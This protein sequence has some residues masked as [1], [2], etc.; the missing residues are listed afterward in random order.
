MQHLFISM[1]EPAS[2]P[3]CRVLCRNAHSNEQLALASSH[4]IPIPTRLPPQNRHRGAAYIWYTG[5]TTKGA[6]AL[7]SFHPAPITY[8]SMRYAAR[9]RLTR[10]PNR[11]RGPPTL[12]VACTS[13]LQTISGA[14]NQLPYLLKVPTALLGET[15]TQRACVAL[16]AMCCQKSGADAPSGG[17]LATALN[18]MSR[19]SGVRSGTVR[20]RVVPRLEIHYLVHAMPFAPDACLPA[21]RKSTPA[22][23]CSPSRRTADKRRTDGG[24]AS[25]VPDAS[26]ECGAQVVG[27]ECK[28]SPAI[29]RSS[30]TRHDASRPNAGRV[31]LT[32]RGGRI[33]RPGNTLPPVRRET[34]AERASESA[35]IRYINDAQYT[36]CAYLSSELGQPRRSSLTSQPKWELSGRGC[37]R[38]Y[39][40]CWRTAAASWS[41]A[42]YVRSVPV[43]TAAAVYVY[44]ARALSGAFAVRGFVGAGARLAVR[45]GCECGCGYARSHGQRGHGARGCASR[46]AAPTVARLV[47]PPPSSIQYNECIR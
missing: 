20:R 37:E 30:Q 24:N 15:A 29:P 22:L 9:S 42:A 32:P 18:R 28:S 36:V 39:R 31:T 8:E 5:G 2:L 4:T 11:F 41:R 1:F 47:T 19:T 40:R 27:A 35:R 43:P 12:A 10:A 6:L 25:I 13:S 3:S 16:R 33:H 44:A 38:G 14:T 45:V 34:T 26:R 46:A 23:P 7:L 21:A 17:A